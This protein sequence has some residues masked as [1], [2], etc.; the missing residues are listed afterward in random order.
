MLTLAMFKTTQTPM[1][2]S[3]QSGQSSVEF[4]L[5]LGFILIPA[6]IAG[7][8]WI[9]QEWSKSECAYQNFKQARIMMIRTQKT[10]TVNGITLLPLEALDQNKGGLKVDDLLKE[11]SQLWVQLSSSSSLF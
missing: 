10:S 3:Q 1:E 2:N 9:K 11:V 5:V 6:L 4:I 7:T 8:A